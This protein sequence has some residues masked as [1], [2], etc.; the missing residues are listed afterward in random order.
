MEQEEFLGIYR[1]VKR[2]RE[3]IKWQHTRYRN[4]FIGRAPS[5]KWYCQEKKHLGQGKGH[6]M[7]ADATCEWPHLSS[8]HWQSAD[9]SGGWYEQ[10]TLK[11]KTVSGLRMCLGE[12]LG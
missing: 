8:V 11:I 2:K 4:L 12:C 5:G 9:G 1:L 10:P 3:P 7:L 6:L